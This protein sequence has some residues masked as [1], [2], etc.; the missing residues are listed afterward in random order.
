MERMNAIIKV[1]KKSHMK[2]ELFDFKKSFIIK[3][4]MFKFLIHQSIWK[5]RLKLTKE[6]Q[7]QNLFQVRAL[8]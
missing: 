7:E 1:I 8:N 3:T 2:L 6:S 5:E 4:W